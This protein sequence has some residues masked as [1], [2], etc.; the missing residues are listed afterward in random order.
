MRLAALGV[1]VGLA[2][3]AA[4]TRLVANLLFDV[5]PLDAT[6]FGAMS[7]LFVGVA[8]LAS[9]LP[10]RRAAMSDPKAALRME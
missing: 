10:A 4:A 9:W 6:T 2:L 3:G 1:G 7:A 5:S 8:L